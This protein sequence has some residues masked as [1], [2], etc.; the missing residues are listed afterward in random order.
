MATQVEALTKDLP[1]VSEEDKPAE[2]AAQWEFLGGRVSENR[3]TVLD[4]HLQCIIC[5]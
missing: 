1:K 4:N 3:K 5:I 2:S